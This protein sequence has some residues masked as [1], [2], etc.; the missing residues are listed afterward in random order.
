MKTFNKKALSMVIMFMMVF[1][2]MLPVNLAYG[3]IGK[4]ITEEQVDIEKSLFEIEIDGA[5]QNSE[6][7]FDNVS[8]DAEITLKYNIS[9]LNDDGI[10]EEPT[11]YDYKPGDFFKLKLPEPISFNIPVGGM[12]LKNSELEVVAYLTLEGENAI[13]TLSDYLEKN[14]SDVNVYFDLSGKFKEELTG[15]DDPKT[16]TLVFEGKT[17]Y[18]GIKPTPP[19]PVDLDIE[20][21]ARLIPEDG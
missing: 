21:D 10:G 18:I 5:T 6:G 4:K 3:S 9:F 8:A 16:I 1:Q 17:I 2:M 15:G 12:E 11:P 19:E 20:K 14:P 13:I 7:N